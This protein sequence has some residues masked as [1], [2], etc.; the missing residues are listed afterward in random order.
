MLENFLSSLKGNVLMM[1]Q[2]L[3]QKCSAT[4][5]WALVFYKWQEKHT[6]NSL[7]TTIL[8]AFAAFQQLWLTC[9]LSIISP[10]LTYPNY[11]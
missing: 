7:I 9:T 2:A 5:V 11:P 3:N 10:Y 1:K 6:E 4:E 8:F